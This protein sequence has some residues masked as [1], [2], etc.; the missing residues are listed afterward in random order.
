[1]DALRLVLISCLPLV[2][3]GCA[4]GGGGG[5][6]HAD[7]DIEGN[8]FSPQTVT[9]EAGSGVFFTNHDATQHSA[10]A[11]DNSWD[12]GTLAQHDEEEIHF[13]DPGTFQYR[14]KFHASMTGT[15]IVE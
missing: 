13:D 8:A 9:V 14:C 2:L 5:H 6:G 15:V 3:S 12:T 11:I 10:T 7:V 4:D 1:M